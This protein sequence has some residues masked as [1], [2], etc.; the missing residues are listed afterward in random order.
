MLGMKCVKVVVDAS[1]G[2]AEEADTVKGSARE[3]SETWG[4]GEVGADLGVSG[5]GVC[6]RRFGRTHGKFWIA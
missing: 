1:G 2:A 3:R 4:W 5:V 6:S